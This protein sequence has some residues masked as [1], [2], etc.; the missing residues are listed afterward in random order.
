M[1]APDY[2]EVHWHQSLTWLQ[3]GDYERGWAA[4]E[5]R[6][7]R[8]RARPHPYK[9]PL[10]DGAPFPGQ[11]VVLHSEQ[12]MGDTLQFVR[13]APLV[14]ERGGTVVLD[15]QPEL[16]GLLSRCPGIDQV[17]PQ[18]NTPSTGDRQAPLLSLPALF[19]TTV[20]TIPA[21]VPYL[22][23]DPPLVERW[24]SR[25]GEGHALKVGIFWQGNPKHKWDRYRS[26]P[27]RCFEPL[28]QVQ[29]VR[30][31]SL[32]KGTG[33]EQL[34]EVAGRWPIEDLAGAFED[35]DGAFTDAAAVLAN[36]DL[37]IGCDS[38]L[39]HLAGALGVRTW[40]LLATVSDWRWLRERED[41]PWY[42][43]L[44]LFRQRQLKDWEEVMLRVRDALVALGPTPPVAPSGEV[45]PVPVSDQKKWAA[46]QA[47]LWELRAE[48]RRCEQAGD[49]GPR[50][51][52]LARALLAEEDRCAALGNPVTGNGVTPE[53]ERAN[54]P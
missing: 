1:V 41:S 9:Q 45:P 25:L 2:P 7:R 50:F 13:Y 23:P 14:K 44:R 22:T 12:G 8:K 33:A 37:V 21:T 10:W 43:S 51:V 24:R 34:A 4:Y 3:L 35:K 19:R 26:V 42:P 6:W 16:V 5:W 31:F 46:V 11:T 52:E 30:L 28:A 18:S 38:A 53:E 49:F 54:Q 32:Q 17:R 39:A 48:A 27:L 36:L 15:C 20:K 29:G 47:R 40:V